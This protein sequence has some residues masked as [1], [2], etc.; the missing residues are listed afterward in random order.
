[1]REKIYSS[2]CMFVFQLSGTTL[3]TGSVQRMAA[4]V[5]AQICVLPA[6]TTAVT[7][8]VLTP[9]TSSRGE[10]GIRGFTAFLSSEMQRS[11]F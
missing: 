4:G 9:A 1:M 8:A 10:G 6:V 2:D 7:G 3:V 11:L 5:R